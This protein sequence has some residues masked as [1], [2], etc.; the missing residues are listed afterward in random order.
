MAVSEVLSRGPIVLWKQKIFLN[1]QNSVALGF[2]FAL[3]ILS[4]PNCLHLI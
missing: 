4:A 2:P 1:S 3:N